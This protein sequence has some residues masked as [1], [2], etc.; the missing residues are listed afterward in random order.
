MTAAAAVTGIQVLRVMR[1]A[2]LS[3][4]GVGPEARITRADPPG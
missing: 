2:F 3:G 1:P 4:C